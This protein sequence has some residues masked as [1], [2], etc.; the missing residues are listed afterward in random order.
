MGHTPMVYG[1]LTVREN[2]EFFS[3]LHGSGLDRSPLAAEAWR[4]MGLERYSGSLASQLSFGW[5]RRLDMVRALLGFPSLLLLDEPF[6]G[7]DQGAS[8]ALSRLLRL[9]LG[10]GLALLMTTPLPDPRYLG[11]AH[12][13]YTLEEG[14]LAEAS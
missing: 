11:L 5:R 4:L 8:E 6:T 7:L 2:I 10:E 12:R 14:V 1:D 3:A 9:A 13:V